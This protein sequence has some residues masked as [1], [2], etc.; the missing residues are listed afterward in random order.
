MTVVLVSIIMFMFFPRDPFWFLVVS[1]IVL[2]PIIAGI[3]YEFI[4]FAGTHQNNIWI[5]MIS[6]PNILLQD[7]TTRQPDEGMMEVAITAIE[8]A[9]E[10]D[11]GA[12][13]SDD[14]SELSSQPF[15][16]LQQSVASISDE[17]EP[18]D[19]SLGI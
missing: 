10:M 1:R 18:P 15:E 2:V 5:R 19:P 8:Y 11:K 16:Y 6:S 13:P 12:T 9:I 3:S 17:G 14:G 4:R 7:L